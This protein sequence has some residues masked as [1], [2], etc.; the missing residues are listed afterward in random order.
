MTPKDTID[1]LYAAFGRGDIPFIVRHIAAGAPFR[2]PASSPWGGDY[3]GPQ[4][5]AEFFARLNDG[6]ETTAFVVDES[7]ETGDQVFSFGTPTATMRK[8]G[9][10]VTVRWMFRWRVSAGTV[11]FYEAYYDAAPIVAALQ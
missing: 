4:G 1:S 11:T 6:A 7:I 2:Q 8:T 10:S 3:S 9:R 5:A